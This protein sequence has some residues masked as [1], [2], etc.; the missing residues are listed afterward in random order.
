MDIA[1]ATQEQKISAAV[2]FL[3]KN[4]DQAPESTRSSL[5]KLVRVNNEGMEI[6]KQTNE[7]KSQIDRLNTLLGE[8]IGAAKLL[9]EIIGEQIPP[10]K[11]DDFARQF[12]IKQFTANE[13]EPVDMAG[14][15]ARPKEGD[16]A[17]S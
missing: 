16:D 5:M 17:K 8:K 10:E 1:H 11:V 4:M 9:F 12:E 7:M 14:I 6:V 13:N 15:T 2:A 3:T